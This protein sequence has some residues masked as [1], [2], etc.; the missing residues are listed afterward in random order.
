ME[1]GKFLLDYYVML[2]ELVGLIIISFISVFITKEA[3]TCTRVIIVLMI[4]TLVTYNL[5]SYT[6]TFEKLSLWRPILTATKYILFPSILLMFFVL[7]STTNSKIKL[8]HILIACIPLM[9]CAPIFYTSQWTHLVCYFTLDNKYHSGV[10]YR[11]PYFLFGVYLVLFVIQNFFIL[12]NYSYHNIIISIYISLGAFANVLLLLVLEL[13]DNYLPV[14]TSSLVLYF[15]FL[16]IHMA[17]VDPLTGLV[18]RQNYYQ[19][20]EHKGDRIT[21]C[22][23]IDMNELKYINDKYGHD[24][25]DK[26]IYTIAKTIQANAGNRSM[27]YRIGGD[28]FVVFYFGV[29]EE[30]VKANIERILQALIATGYSC[31]I[32]YSMKEGKEKIEEVMKRADKKMY[33]NK[34]IMK[35]NLKTIL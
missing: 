1:F 27:A 5:E 2:F 19:D 9:I 13:S 26:A 35:Q 28:E 22:V 16:Y 3:K 11:L 25:G 33:E 29:K 21:S 10:L 14:F 12:K 17:G 24:A 20:M 6:Q 18:N 4:I 15:L 31:A 7:L 32:G 34:A 8:K 30:D 23:S